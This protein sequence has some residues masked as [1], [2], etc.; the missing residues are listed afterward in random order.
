MTHDE[1]INYLLKDLGQRGVGKYTVAPPAFRLLW[2]M[3]IEVPPPHFAGFWSL[4]LGMGTFFGVL[5]GIFMWLLF[6]R[7]QDLSAGA[8]VGFSALA[9]LV[10]G[11]IMAGY[12]RW[13]R[14]R[15]ALPRWEDYPSLPPQTAN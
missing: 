7:A 4:A 2:R 14:R 1:K 12:Y 5:W 8:V 11:L 3:G 9:G 10:F 6:W 15:L 13:H